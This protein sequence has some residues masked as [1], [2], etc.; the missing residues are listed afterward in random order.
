MDR[1]VV[2]R[3]GKARL[4]LRSRRQLRDLDDVLITGTITRLTFNPALDQMPVW[5]PDGV[6]I[7]FM[8]QRDGNEEIYM[9]YSDGFGQPARVTNHPAR[10]NRPAWADEFTLLFS[11]DRSG[12]ASQLFR[13]GTDGT[14]LQLIQNN[15]IQAQEP[16]WS[17]D[18][19]RLTF[20]SNQDGDPDI[21]RINADGTA[22]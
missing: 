16:D 4:D 20:I 7:A 5:S 22:W 14:G 13:V 1:V 8:S 6:E 21:Y 15:P 9:M 3:G 2:A 18:G 11:S 12:V 17:P 10:D 19:S